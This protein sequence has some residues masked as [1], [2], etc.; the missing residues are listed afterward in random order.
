MGKLQTLLRVFIILGLG[1]VTF[2]YAMFQGGFVSWFLF[3]STTVISVVLLLVCLMPIG[4]IEVERKFSADRLVVGEDLKI[5][6]TLYRKFPFPIFYFVAEDVMLNKNEQKTSKFIIYPFFRRDFDFSYSLNGLK[7]GEYQFVKVKLHTSD[8]FGMFKKMK[9]I[10]VKDDVVVY[11][12]FQ[13]IESLNIYNENETGVN[14]TSQRLI[15]DITSVAGAREY[16]PGDRLTSIDWKG[17]ARINKLM[18][19][20]FEQY[21]GQRFLI[22]LDCSIIDKGKA[23]IFEKAVE[24]ATSLTVHSYK[25]N[26]QIGLLT[27]GD[28]AN[29]YPINLAKSHQ[30]SL[31][32]HLA[33]LNYQLGNT[34]DRVFENEI[35]KIATDSIV[36]L[37]TTRITAAMVE[38]VHR[39]KKKRVQ[40]VFCFVS[41]TKRITEDENNKLHQIMGLD[42][43]GYVVS[44]DN[45]RVELKGGEA[46]AQKS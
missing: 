16:I 35:R 5:T 45:F 17:T 29:G 11:P 34:F 43:L 14:I 31:L 2:F 25:K 10:Y 8:F 39:L 28:K 21:L 19:K 38:N 44:G 15:E 30:G 23:Q 1:T 37:I 41:E 32:E 13:E 3:Y 26:H 42:V 12:N 4:D 7:R 27:I 18:T 40:I 24:L 22:T 36:L 20:E 46:V 6:I 33:K 9:V